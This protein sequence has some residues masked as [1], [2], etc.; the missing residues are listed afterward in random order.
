MILLWY[1]VKAWNHPEIEEN[2]ANFPYKSEEI[3]QT[4]NARE[5]TNIGDLRNE[6]LIF[7]NEKLDIYIQGL[8]SINYLMLIN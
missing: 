8:I 1:H 2:F 7:I 3:L 4:G 6:E 5:R